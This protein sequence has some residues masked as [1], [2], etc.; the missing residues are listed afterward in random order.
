MSYSI[1]FRLKVVAFLCKG[2]SQRKAAELFGINLE[3]INKWYQKYRDTGDISNEPLNRSFKKID[4]EKLESFVNR[5]PD[6][7][8]SEIA[9][10]FSCSVA[11]IHKALKRL[12]ITRKKN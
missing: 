11:A 8:L 10:E 2:N 1:D 3:T 7:Y 5:Y 9:E 12:G 4:P 6:S